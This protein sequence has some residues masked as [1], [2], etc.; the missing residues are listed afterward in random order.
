MLIIKTN[1]NLLKKGFLTKNL[2]FF[3]SRKANFG[4]K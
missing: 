4:R 3:D 1:E 2:G